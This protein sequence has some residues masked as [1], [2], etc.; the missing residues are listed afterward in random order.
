MAKRDYYEI[1]GVSKDA[2][3]DEIKRAYRK[4]SKQYHPDINKEPGA[5][6]KFKEISE[7]YEVLS[8]DTKRAQY[9]QFGHAGAN[10]D[11]DG[12]GGFGGFSDAGFGG[13]EDI[14]NTF[15]G[16]G[17]TRRRNPNAPRQGADLQYTM[18]LTFEEAVFGKETDIEIPR[19]EECSTCHGSGA[20]PGTHP[21]E[22]PYCH[23]SGQISTEQNTPF[24]RIVNRR[25]CHHCGGTG[26]VIKHKCPT[27]HGTGKVKKRKKIHIK[28]PAGIDNGQQLRVAGKGEPGINGGPNGDL[29]IIFQ[30]KEHEFFE[31]DGDDIYC[32]MPISFVQAALGDEIE[33]P[34]LH[35]KVKLKIPAGTQTNTKFRLRGKGVKSVRSTTPGDQHVIVRIVTPTKLTEKQKQLLREFA[36]ISGKTP[37]EQTDTFFEKVKRAFKGE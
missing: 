8:D 35:G 11:F 37:D 32:E 26:Q 23:G 3:K 30:V 1:L 22:C 4:L 24:G 20:K 25:V 31:R 33:V 19:E 9:D 12:F 5:D 34:T 16:G 21:E 10:Q 15:F 28:I 14:L 18:T 13:F 7:A 17:S 2:S 29:Y 27:C 6:E 36:E